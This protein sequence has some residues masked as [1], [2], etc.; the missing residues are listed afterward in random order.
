MNTLIKAV[1]QE[2][3]LFV[4]NGVIK[5]RES[6]KPSLWNYCNGKKNLADMV[7]GFPFSLSIEE[8]FMVGGT[9]LFRRCKWTNLMYKRKSK[10]RNTPKNDTTFITESI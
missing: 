3:K 8:V 7:T 10:I 6:V 4:Q 9:C 2:F 1:N 5:I